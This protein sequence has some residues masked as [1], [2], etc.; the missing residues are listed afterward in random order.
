MEGA[1]GLK[2]KID[3]ERERPYPEGKPKDC[4]YLVWPPVIA[5]THTETE[6]TH[7]VSLQPS[8]SLASS[9]HPSLHPLI[10]AATLRVRLSIQRAALTSCFLQPRFTLRLQSHSD[11]QL[12]SHLAALKARF[13]DV[14]FYFNL[15][16][17]CNKISRPSFYMKG[18]DLITNQQPH[19]AHIGTN[20]KVKTT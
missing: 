19:T 15:G 2:T 8:T 10:P 16:C 7:E 6:H 11:H 5:M 13:L 3:R 14:G 4:C 12:R 20:K 1:G 17:Y 9:L 18:M